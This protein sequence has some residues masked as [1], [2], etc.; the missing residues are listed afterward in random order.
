MTKHQRKKLQVV[1]RSTERIILSVSK[2]EKIRNS[3][4]R[5]KTGARDILYTIY[6]SKV[7]YSGQVTQQSETRWL[8]E[9]MK[10]V[11]WD[12]K[13]GRGRPAIRGRDDFVREWGVL[14]AREAQDREN[15]R[16]IREV[17]AQKWELSSAA[18]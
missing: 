16:S 7:K 8:K 6:R 2:R 5:E 15:W 17:C 11:P 3:Y 1:Q 12:Q 13:R 9:V 14:W 10:W 4:I 18:T